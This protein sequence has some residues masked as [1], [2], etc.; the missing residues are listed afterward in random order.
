M[1]MFKNMMIFTGNANAPLARSICEVLGTPLGRCDV[2]RFSDGETWVEIQENVRGMDVFVIQPTANPANEHLME[3]LIMIDALKRSS[4]DRITAVMPYYGYGRQ[5]RKV[6]PR[7]PISAKLVADLLTAAGADR[8]LSMDLHAG[9]IQGFFNIPFDHLYSMPILLDH[10]REQI[11]ENIVIVAPDAGGAERARAYAKR[12]ACPLALIDKRRP[13]PNVTEVMHVIGSV[14]GANA[15]IVDDM[16]DTGGT[17]ARSVEALKQKGASTVHA[18]CT[19]GVLSGNAVETIDQSLI[20]SLVVT[21]TIKANSAIAGST[22]IQVLSIA[23]LLAEAIRRI[24]QS[25]SVSSLFV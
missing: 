18:Y 2:K 24:Y 1:Q 19:H 13:Q 23:T 9:Q 17:L 25:D 3:L 4:A 21:D 20:A 7:T 8:I 12:L 15:V 22:H 11:G 10:I 6:Q 16:V 5:E 14:E